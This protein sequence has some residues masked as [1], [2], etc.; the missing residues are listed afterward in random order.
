MRKINYYLS[1]VL[2]LLLL[3]GCDRE[4]LDNTSSSGMT[5]EQ[6]QEISESSN[7]D[8]E[9]SG[10]NFD[11]TV[12]KEMTENSIVNETEKVT[13]EEVTIEEPTTEEWTVTY[14]EGEESPTGAFVSSN[15]LAEPN[16]YELDITIPNIP[17]NPNSA[18]SQG[19][20]VTVRIRENISFTNIS[21]Y[22]RYEI[23]LRD[24]AQSWI[25][26]YA[27]S[28][29]TSYPHT[30][31]YGMKDLRTDEYLAV[32]RGE[33]ASVVYVSLATPLKSGERMTL[34]FEYDL[35]VCRNYSVG[36]RTHYDFVTNAQG[37]M[38]PYCELG[39]F[40]PM[41]AAWTQTGWDTDPTFAVGEAVF[42]PI[43]D[44]NITVHVPTGWT[45]ISAGEEVLQ[46]SQNGSDT[47][48]VKADNI[49]DFYV[50]T[51]PAYQMKE[52]EW[53]G[54]KIRAYA[55]DQGGNADIFLAQAQDAIAIFSQVYGAYPYDSLD[56][57]ESKISNSMETPQLI[58][59]SDHQW[60]QQA[61]SMVVV[62]ETAHQWFYSSV[63]N[64][65]YKE[66]WLDESLAQIS[67]DIYR[68]YL[69]GGFD[70]DTRMIQLINVL[71]EETNGMTIDMTPAE[72]GEYY[73]KVIYN[74]GE[75]FLI[76]LRQ[77]MGSEAF[78]QMLSEYYDTYESK[79]GT[80]AKFLSILGNY[81]SENETAKALC[82]E[83]LRSCDF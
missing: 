12:S 75:L 26:N 36:E 27:A 49:R 38:Q 71:P 63:G 52:T 69:Y 23:C 30:T 5:L 41:L 33:S 64:D 43:A 35:P 7:N 50:M 59:I 81:I 42:S 14:I 76:Q 32:R 21:E 34:S 56:I 20:Y 22:T 58:L 73:V 11:D 13:V 45:V 29:G 55:Y 67:E 18:F 57:V 10:E 65:Q 15:I 77:A 62:H 82:R 66:A 16:A 60:Y 53:N 4:T 37:E 6:S 46:Q 2:L 31:Y 40:Y 44:Y 28:Y 1:G 25:E 74:K 48:I 19:E 51:S 83:Y 24:Y 78:E 39:S 61:D 80:T 47:W 72:L 70:W 3:S 9:V 54:I 79:I 68:E 17:Y 8:A